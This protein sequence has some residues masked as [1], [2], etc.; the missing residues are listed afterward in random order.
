MEIVDFAHL[1]QL[2]RDHD[3]VQWGGSLEAII[4]DYLKDNPHGRTPI[5]MDT[6]AQLPGLPVTD[7]QLDR[8]AITVNG[9][10]P[11]DT[12]ALKE[13]LL[14]FFPWRKGPFDL[15]G[16]FIDTEWRSD[17][18]WDR[19]C[20]RISSLKDRRVLDIGCGNGYYLWRILGEGARCAI[21]AD[22]MRLYCAQF[23]VIRHFVGKDLPVSVLPVG[24]EQLPLDQPVFD[25][26]FSMGVLYHRRE[27]V[28]HIEQLKSLLSD[29]GELVLE[30]LIIE[31]DR[32]TSLQPDDRYAQMR[33]V[34]HIPSVSQVESWLDEAGFKDMKLVDISRT[35]L[36][37]QRTTEWMP[38]KSLVDFL[39]PADMDKTVEG[40]PAP[41]RAVVTAHI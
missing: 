2:L 22:P 21:G 37:E 16:I 32:A 31:D 39:D 24:I 25:T 6:I 4:R 35:S 3:L 15:H 10:T 19:V 20:S 27:P 5:W 11:F 9:D 33:N 1:N 38:F 14:S 12:D 34:W 29:D 28:A 17:M 23:Q 7:I 13:Q 30:T 8:P 26:I 36:D 18:K 41:V 40:Y